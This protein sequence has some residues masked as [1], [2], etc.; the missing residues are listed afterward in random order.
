M[1]ITKIHRKIV[2]P[3]LQP[4]V[5]EEK[6]RE[7]VRK[8]GNV[9]LYSCF[10]PPSFKI[11]SETKLVIFMSLSYERERERGRVREYILSSADLS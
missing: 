1:P 8:R 3:K 4:T 10:H 11:G 5:S 2:S 9:P 7:F 6:L